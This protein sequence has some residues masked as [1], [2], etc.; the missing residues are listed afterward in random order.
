MFETT[1]GK[2]E[3]AAP[4]ETG[5]AVTERIIVETEED[6][7]HPVTR[8]VE[9]VVTGSGIEEGVCVV[10]CPHTSASVI[11]N[12]DDAALRDDILQTLYDLVP[13]D[14]EADYR[15]G[16]HEH[17]PNAHAHLKTL[18]TGSSITIPV[19]DGSMVL[20][21]YQTV[22]LLDTDGPR[23]REVVVQVLEG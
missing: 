18:L 19:Q 7:L 13:D 1:G 23:R 10:F 12:E 21:T 11:I 8:D 3:K 15:H 17:Q 4:E 22:F 9:Q 16:T 14:A 5:M 2:A 6:G 20:G